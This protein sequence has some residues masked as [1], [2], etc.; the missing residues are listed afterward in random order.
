MDWTRYKALCDAP[1]VWSRWFIERLLD[2]GP[3]SAAAALTAA[4]AGAPLQ[5]PADHRGGRETEMFRVSL[6]PA[7]VMELLASVRRAEATGQRPRSLARR[8]LGG[9]TEALLE[10]QR[11][12][13]GADPSPASAAGGTAGGAETA[14]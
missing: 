5:R 3:D 7:D 8:G 9:F 11:F 14:D 4:L 6:V 2:L 10:Y 12:I 13:A 1:D